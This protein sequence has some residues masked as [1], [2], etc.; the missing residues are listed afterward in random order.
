MPR[1]TRIYC[2]NLLISC[3]ESTPRDG[4]EDASA[5]IMG[6][7]ARLID[8]FCGSKGAAAIAG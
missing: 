2:E 5:F 1:K 3:Q 6:M 4:T 7:F 8:A